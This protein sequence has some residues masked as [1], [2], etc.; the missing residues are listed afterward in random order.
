MTYSLQF[1]SLNQLFIIMLLIIMNS[2]TTY[3]STTKYVKQLFIE[4][5]IPSDDGQ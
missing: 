1:T 4:L 2:Y 3:V 5:A